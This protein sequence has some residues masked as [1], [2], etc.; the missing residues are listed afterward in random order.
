MLQ[1]FP[2]IAFCLAA[3]MPTKKVRHCETC[4]AKV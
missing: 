1:S 4:P 3:Y 2:N